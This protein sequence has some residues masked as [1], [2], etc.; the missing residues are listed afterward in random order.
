MDARGFPMS[1][2]RA[3]RVIEAS[4]G[5]DDDFGVGIGNLRLGAMQELGEV[6]QGP[7]GAGPTSAP[8]KSRRGYPVVKKKTLP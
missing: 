7:V 1:E 8:C 4:V 6:Q 3:T 5:G 2:R